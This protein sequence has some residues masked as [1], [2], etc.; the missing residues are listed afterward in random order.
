MELGSDDALWD[1]STVQP[2]APGLLV[3]RL[4]LGVQPVEIAGSDRF[5]PHVC[6]LLPLSFPSSPHSSLLLDNLL[7]QTIPFR[8]VVSVATTRVLSAHPKRRR[9]VELNRYRAQRADDMSPTTVIAEPKEFCDKYFPVN[10]D[11][12]R[13]DT[14]NP[15][16]KIE[17][18]KKS[19]GNEAEIQKE[20]VSACSDAFISSQ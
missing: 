1:R 9:R 7:T 14:T 8:T 17:R 12:P 13:P 5:P 15:F 6:V 19:K 18:L 20:F 16:K 10:P 2:R 3:V 11:N 4:Q